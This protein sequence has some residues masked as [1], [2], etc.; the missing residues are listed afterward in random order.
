MMGIVTSPAAPPPTRSHPTARSMTADARDGATIRFARPTDSAT[1]MARLI[2][3]TDEVFRFLFGVDPAAIGRMAGLVSAPFNVFSHRKTIVF[4]SE[5]KQIIGILV[6]HAP[7]L[8]PPAGN[9]DDF[10]SV[11]TGWQLMRLW[12]RSLRIRALEDKS[13]IDGLYISNICVHEGA[14]GLG[15]GAKLIAFIEHSA[16]HT[17]YRSLWLDV[18]A[19]NDGARRLYERLGFVVQSERRVH[20]APGRFHRMKKDLMG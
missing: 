4:E 10:S 16:R 12:W 8:E 14:R 17:G 13:C 11:F 19:G 15:I 18:A 3:Q 1:D 7:S 6:A 5:A 2:L 9:D 20:V